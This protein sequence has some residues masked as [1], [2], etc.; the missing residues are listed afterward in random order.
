MLRVVVVLM[1]VVQNGNRDQPDRLHLGSL[2][3]RCHRFSQ[4]E[5]EGS[6]EKH[7]SVNNPIMSPRGSSSSDSRGSTTPTCPQRKEG[8][9]GK[10]LMRWYIHLQRSGINSDLF[11]VALDVLEAFS[12]SSTALHSVKGIKRSFP[13]R[14]RAHFHTNKI[15]CTTRIERSGTKGKQVNKQNDVGTCGGGGVEA[16]MKMSG[17]PLEPGTGGEPREDRR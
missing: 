10:R 9:D 14:A 5:G 12:G 3:G 6:K 17:F 13:R 8:N 7:F 11:N 16:R 2:S 1:L 15:L 4:F